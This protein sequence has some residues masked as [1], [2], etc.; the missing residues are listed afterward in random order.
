MHRIILYSL[1]LLAMFLSTAGCTEQKVYKIGVSQC[2]RD[3]WRTKMNDEINREIMFHEEAVVEIRSADDD[4]ARQ[5]ED[6]RY[7]AD[8]GFDI[9]I[10]SPNEAAELTPVIREVYESGLPVIIFDRNIIGDTYTARIGVDDEA[11]G[12]SAAHYALHLLGEGQEAIEICGLTGSTPAKGRHDGF[13]RVYV[14]GGGRLRASVPADWNKEDAVRVA[15]SLLRLYPETGLIY[16][17]NDRMAIGASEVARKAGRDDIKII[18][19]DAAPEIGIR[20]VADSL[21]DA[22][23]LYPTRCHV[24]LPD[25]GAPHHSDGSGHSQG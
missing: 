20:A 3:D 25:G 1:L 7:F 11:I 5:I 9:V 17:H 21:I 24:P 4:N 13:A 19:I 22:T 15:D 6:I 8:N 12:R 14:E 16:A 23:F 18:G 10:V 2:S